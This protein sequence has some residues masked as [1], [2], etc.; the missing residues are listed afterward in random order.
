MLPSTI[1]AIPIITLFVSTISAAQTVD[2][3]S[4]FNS[5]VQENRVGLAKKTKLVDARPAKL[6]EVV[7]T[8]IKNEGKET[9][10]SPAKAGDMV[11]KNRC[12]ETGNEEIL[13]SAKKF[14]QRYEGP[15]TDKNPNLS[16]EWQTYRPKGNEMEYFIVTAKEGQFQFIAPWGEEMKAYPGDAIVRV[17]TDHKDTYR[18]AKAAFNCTYEIIRPAK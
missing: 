12:P 5:A 6:D 1:R 7:V 16:N 15:L 10:S 3:Q 18:I 13:V 14:V 4:L 17:P 8:I 11:V 9:Q 2:I